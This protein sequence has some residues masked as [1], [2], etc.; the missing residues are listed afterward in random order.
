MEMISMMHTLLLLKLKIEIS[1]LFVEHE[2]VEL[3]SAGTNLRITKE[4]LKNLF[5]FT[6]FLMENTSGIEDLFIC[7]VYRL[8]LRVQV[9]FGIVELLFIQTSQ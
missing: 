8:L 9:M 2:N 4:L 6:K 3:Y 1:L 7:R 5:C